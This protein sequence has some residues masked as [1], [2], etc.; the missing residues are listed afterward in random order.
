MQVLNERYAEEH[1]VG[2]LAFLEMDAKVADTQKI[3]KL[4]QAAS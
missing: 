1:M 2:I 3:S 4:V